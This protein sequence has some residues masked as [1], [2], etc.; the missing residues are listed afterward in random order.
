[1]RVS[2]CIEPGGWDPTLAGV[3]GASPL[4]LLLRVNVLN[5]WRRLKSV[6]KTSGAMALAVASFVVAY[7]ALSFLLFSF[8]PKANLRIS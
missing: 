7:Q 1:M 4:L 2:F 3:N 6:H 5:L 8:S